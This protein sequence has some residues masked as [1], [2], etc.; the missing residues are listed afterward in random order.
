M[1]ILV[2]TCQSCFYENHNRSK[3]CCGCGNRLAQGRPSTQDTGYQVGKSGG[4]PHGSTQGAGYG[5]GK[6]GGRPCGRRKGI[7]FDA[8]IELPTNWDHSEEI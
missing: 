8:C 5:V 6:S 4:R 2:K 3:V 1:P 7:D